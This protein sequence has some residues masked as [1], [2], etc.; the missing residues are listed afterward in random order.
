MKLEKDEINIQHLQLTK[1]AFRHRDYNKMNLDEKSEIDIAFTNTFFTV[2]KL[3]IHGKINPNKYY[4][5]WIV[6]Q[7]ELDFFRELEQV[8]S[9]ASFQDFFEKYT[10][11]NGY[12]NGIKD[13]IQ[14]YK[15]LPNDTLLNISYH[16]I[17]K[18][19]KKLNYYNDAQFSDF[20]DNIS[21]DFTEALKRFQ[22]R[23]GLF[24][25]GKIDDETLIELNVSKEDR[26][27]QLKVNLERARWFY[28]DLGQHYVMVNLPE[29]KLFL[30]SNGNLLQQHD[31]IIGTNE[32]KTPILS[33][34]FNNLILNPTWTIPPTILK[35]D[36]VPKA[37]YN[38]DYFSNNRITIYDKKDKAVDPLNWNSD[39]FKNYRYVQSP[40]SN[41]A[42][43]LIKFDFPNSHSVYLH[44][45]SNRSF[46]LRKNRDLSSGCVRVKDPFDLAIEI[47]K[48]EAID[49][50]MADLENI[51]NIGNTKRIPLKQKVKIHQHYW[52][53]WKDENGIQ[54]RKD[55]YQLDKALYKR[56]IK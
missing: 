39:L 30:F 51:I 50:S 13:A 11:K 31:I 19:K 41:N 16:D 21:V 2:S 6:P 36:V 23:H 54:F 28:N 12:Y 55:I 49:Y 52:T 18:I 42:L 45:T 10:P 43:G 7:R 20:S 33:S 17:S 14:I 38:L 37:T 27:R 34:S 24:P 15:K 4:S 29:C 56:L 26:L 47:L 5:D 35:N 40:G 46:F 48:I 9:D 8:L 25:N 22:K 44:D 3:F 32:R 1:L 53:A